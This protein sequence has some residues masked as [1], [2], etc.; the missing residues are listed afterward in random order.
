M[1]PYGS[2]LHICPPK[3]ENDVHFNRNIVAEKNNYSIGNYVCFQFTVK[4]LVCNC[5]FW[6]FDCF[7]DLKVSII[8]VKFLEYIFLKICLK[9]PFN[10]GKYFRRNRILVCQ[11]LYFS[12][13]FKICQ[14]LLTHLVHYIH[15]RIFL[16]SLCRNY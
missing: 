6:I 16:H 5:L 9:K 4:I 14:G 13:N 3:R 1:L 11:L 7:S 15:S 12:S 8:H 10:H 2:T